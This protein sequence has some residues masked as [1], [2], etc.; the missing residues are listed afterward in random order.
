MKI[1]ARMLVVVMSVVMM[2][3]AF[4]ACS[5]EK[6]V[7]GDWTVSTINGKTCEEYAAPLGVPA[8]M[9]ALN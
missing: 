2:G 9:V 5:V 6:D 1:I 7:V 3:M 8:N 4:T